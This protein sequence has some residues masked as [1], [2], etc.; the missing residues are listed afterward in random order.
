MCLS[1]FISHEK[2]EKR[3]HWSLFKTFVITEFRGS[4]SQILMN[5]L[6]S[7]FQLWI[8][9][10]WHKNVNKAFRVRGRRTMHW[11]IASAM[12]VWLKSSE[13][14]SIPSILL[15]LLFKMSVITSFRALLWK[16]QKYW[17]IPKNKNTIEENLI[18]VC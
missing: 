13:Q 4:L 5:N 17:T 14:M 3:M 11:R 10:L 1:T 16:S 9:T 12:C 15:L 7:T 2:K 6:P 18:H 8:Q